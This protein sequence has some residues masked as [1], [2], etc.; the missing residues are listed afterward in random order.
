ME[1]TGQSKMNDNEYYEQLALLKEICKNM[2]HAPNWLDLSKK[3]GLRS[4]R[5]FVKHCPNPNVSDYNSF[6]EKEIGIIPSYNMSK[7]MVL[8]IV[9]IEAGKLGRR[10][11]KKDFGKGTNVGISSSL[12]KKT[13]GSFENLASELGYEYSHFGGSMYQ[14]T[15]DEI[16]Y[17]TKQFILSIDED[18]FTINEY[19]KY[20]KN[21]EIHLAFSTA[22]NNYEEEIGSRFRDFFL[23]FGKKLV[24]PGR[25]KV[26][27][28]DDGEKCFSTYEIVFST[29]LKERYNMIYNQDYFRDIRYSSFLSDIKTKQ[30]CDY[31][32]Q[33]RN[34][35]VEIAGVLRYYE[36]F[37]YEDDVILSSESKEKYRISLS[38]KERYLKI[39]K[40]PYLF[41]FPNKYKD[42][43]KQSI[44]ILDGAF[45]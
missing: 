2:S 23:L 10:P 20:M 12:V 25:G 6:M 28:F 42:F 26:K 45:S 16:I 24:Y 41:I 32:F 37:F 7:E 21:N 13:F 15:I 43:E 22:K 29:L 34:L 30:N 14:K 5:W 44:S 33:N 18:E 35:V 8:G 39:L 31:F 19:N 1:R 38:E 9:K 17:F 11:M 27:I 3:Y 4:S 40:I 36:R